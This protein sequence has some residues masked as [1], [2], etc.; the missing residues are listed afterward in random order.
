M[1]P[2]AKPLLAGLSLVALSCAGST[3][4]AVTPVHHH[5]VPAFLFGAFDGPELDVRNDCPNTSAES[6]RI[7]TTWSTLGLSILTLGIYTP[8]EVS[9][10]CKRRGPS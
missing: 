9:I 1:T 7:G 5:V 3:P 2:P 4:K 10:R 8:R 6:I